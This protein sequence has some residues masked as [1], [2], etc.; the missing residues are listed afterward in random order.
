MKH[1]QS[2]KIQDQIE[3]QRIH[4]KNIIE[5]IGPS[6]ILQSIQKEVRQVHL[7]FKKYGIS[8]LGNQLRDARHRWC[9]AKTTQEKKSFLLECNSLIAQL[10]EKK[11]NMPLDLQEKEVIVT[12]LFERL[13]DAIHTGYLEKEH[14]RLIELIDQL[15]IMDQCMLYKGVDELDAAGIAQPPS[16][17]HK[18]LILSLFSTPALLYAYAIKNIT[19]Q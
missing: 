6:D 3:K 18:M 9:K 8:L 14:E 19:L 5:T 4:I 7:L 15:A 1:V 12:Q 13:F 2:K 16:F 17:F 11:K 10:V